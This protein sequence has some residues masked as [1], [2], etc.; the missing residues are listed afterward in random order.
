IA[1]QHAKYDANPGGNRIPADF[2]RQ[3]SERL[4]WRSEFLARWEPGEFR[5]EAPVSADRVQQWHPIPQYRTSGYQM[6]DEGLSGRYGRRPGVYG[7]DLRRAGAR[8][9]GAAGPIYAHGGRQEAT[10]HQ[11]GGEQRGA[12]K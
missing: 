10:T 11:V 8:L 1:G 4:G 3:D 12:E 2:R 5:V 6:G 9:Y 7:P